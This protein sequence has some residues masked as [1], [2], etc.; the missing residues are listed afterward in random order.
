MGELVLASTADGSNPRP[1]SAVRPIKTRPLGRESMDCLCP[2][3]TP[4]ADHTNL[5]LSGPIPRTG[6][7]CG[8]RPRDCP[9][10][11]GPVR[12]GCPRLGPSS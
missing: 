6:V 11:P 12:P 1:W 4:V 8:F 9:S 5:E 7:V 2:Q 10:R 3:Y